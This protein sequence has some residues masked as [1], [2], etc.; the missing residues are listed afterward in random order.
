MTCLRSWGLASATA[1]AQLAEAW[2]ASCAK[3]RRP[4]PTRDAQRRSCVTGFAVTSLIARGAPPPLA[5][6]QRRSCVA[7]FAVTSLCRSWGPTPTRDAQRRSYVAGFA[8][9]IGRCQRAEP[10]RRFSSPSWWRSFPVAPTRNGLWPRISARTRPLRRRSASRCLPRAW[11]S[12]ITMSDS[13]PVPSNHRSTTASAP[14]GC[15]VP[16][17]ASA[18]RSSSFISR[19][20][21]GQLRP[22]R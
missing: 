17:T 21:P 7:G 22:I 11:R 16:A 19:S 10:P 18:S 9:P 13:T 15:S 1:P 6:A 3:R 12:T 2:L 14:A 20:T 8:V 5:T 4:T